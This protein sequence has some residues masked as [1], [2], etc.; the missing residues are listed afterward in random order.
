M[1]PRGLLSKWALLVVASAAAGFVAVF[2]IYLADGRSVSGAFGF[3]Q[4][5]ALFADGVAAFVFAGP[6]LTAWFFGEIYILDAPNDFNLLAFA[7]SLPSTIVVVIAAIMILG[8]ARSDRRLPIW[9]L[10]ICPASLAS[11]TL[12]FLG[13]WVEGP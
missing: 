12:A 3:A 11:T 10:T 2:S 1:K 6:L 13:L 4:M 7:A 8:E 9:P 5:M